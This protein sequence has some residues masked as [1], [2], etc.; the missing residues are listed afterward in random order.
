[1]LTTGA[2]SDAVT[3]RI[4]LAEDES[5]D[6]A[7]QAFNLAIDQRPMAVA[8]P[9]DDRDV[10]SVVDLARERG[11]RIAAQATGH[12]AGPLGSLKIL[13]NIRTDRCGD[14]CSTPGCGWGPRPSG[15]R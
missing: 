9:G 3:G 15:R 6:M 1:M 2:L 11:L 14:R 8:F 13:V 12:N 10:A 7:R 4:V 5:W